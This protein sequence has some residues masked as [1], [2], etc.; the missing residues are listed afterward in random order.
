MDSWI[1]HMPKGMF[2]KSDGF[3]SDISDPDG[4]LTLRRFCAERGIDYRDTGIPVRLDTFSAYGLAFRDRKVPEVEDKQIVSVD[5]TTDGFVL[6]LDD[7]ETVRTRR[8][9]LAVGITHF[10]YIPQNL[11]DL[12]REFLSHSANHNDP[13]SF[14]GRN[15][16]VIGAGSSAL[17]LAALLHE[18]G[19]DVQLVA[20]QKQLKFHGKPSGKPRTLWQRMRHPQ[21]GLGPGWKTWFFA[22]WPMV[23]H[24]LPEGFRLETV[25]TVLGP[26]GG[27]F[28]K[29]KIVGKVPLHL[30]Y[31]IQAAKVTQGKA[32]LNLVAEDGSR[33]ELTADH[34][35]A[36]TGYKVDLDRLNFLSQQIRSRLKSLNHAPVLSSS[37]E[38]SIPGLYFVGVAAANSFGPLMRFA[39]GA[40]FAAITV[41]KAVAKPKAPESVML[42]APSPVSITK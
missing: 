37:F 24:Y 13:E 20:R 33:R 18:A 14:R 29:D 16:I 35:V 2:L 39:F 25:R 34:V 4:D 9:V 1:A 26:S 31:T 7:G 17:D 6:T 12:P 42:P 23:F 30:G 15:V 21:S 11:A 32:V 38:S 3:A 8:V 36:A 19:A 28:I 22:N 5:Q 40:S 27:W 41:A 10:D